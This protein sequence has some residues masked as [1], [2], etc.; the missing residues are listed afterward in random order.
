MRQRPDFGNSAALQKDRFSGELI[1]LSDMVCLLRFATRK[2][3][4]GCLLLAFITHQ[5][6]FVPFP[7]TVLDIFALI[8]GL[9][10]FTQRQ[11]HFGAARPVKIYR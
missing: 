10:T 6:R 3:A 5:P 4:Y 8:L 9:A 1:M 7:I 2:I 11:L